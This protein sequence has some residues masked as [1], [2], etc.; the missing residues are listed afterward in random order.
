[1]KIGFVSLGCSKNLVDSEYILGMFPNQFEIEKDPA[2]CEVIVINTCGFI[3]SAKE[4]SINTIL[5]MADYKQDKLKCLIVTGCLVQRYKEEL[6]KELPEVDYFVAI[7]EYDKLHE[8]LAK[9]L[10]E[11]I[12]YKFGENRKMVNNSYYAYLKISEGCNNRCAFCAIPLIRG[13]VKSVPM[14]AL[15]EEAK[16][17]I[18]IGVKELNIV[19][20]DSNNYGLDIYGERRIKDLLIELNKL[21]FKW[22]R[23]LYM[24][25]D[26]INEEL[27]SSMSKL[28]KVLPYFD[29]P[30][31]YGS[32]TVLKWMRRCPKE[33]VKE[34]ISLIRKYYDNPV[35]RTS[36]IVGFPYETEESLDETIEFIK[37]IRFNSL[38]AFT[39]SREE[40]T[41]AYDM[42][43]IEEEIKVRRLDK[44]MTVQKEIAFEIANSF[45]GKTLEVLIEREES[46]F[47]RY[48]GRAY[49]S[50]PD[51]VDGVVFVR[52]ENLKVGEFYNVEIT[53]TNEYDLLGIV[54]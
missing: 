49:N 50:A 48:V 30:I 43:Q 5:E 40:D 17:L 25:P 1:M 6:E 23:I 22:I 20:Q 51:G 13:N 7:K 14:E 31:Q 27:I 37:E 38:G 32:D 9:A 3:N 2:K 46:I 41:P 39:Y 54:R 16:R 15:L 34:K 12:N 28:E 11:E 33:T 19:A 53:G 35:I 42:P 4:E 29:M 47:N 26:E 8:I 10:E 21:D 52:G 24:Y 36:M 45:V 18:S 44:L